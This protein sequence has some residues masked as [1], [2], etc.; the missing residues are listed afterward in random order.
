MKNALN[1]RHKGRKCI[2]RGLRAA[3]NLLAVPS[4]HRQSHPKLYTKDALD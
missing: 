4:A 2:F 3:Y 1:W